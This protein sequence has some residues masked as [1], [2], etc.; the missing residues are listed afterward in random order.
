MNGPRFDLAERF[1][2]GMLGRLLIERDGLGA[3]RIGSKFDNDRVTEI[4]F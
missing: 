2:A 4:G 3:T 1:E